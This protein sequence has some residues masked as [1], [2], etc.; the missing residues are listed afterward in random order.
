MAD[1]GEKHPEIA[2]EKGIDADSA[3]GS[4]QPHQSDQ[5]LARH[6]KVRPLLPHGP[7]SP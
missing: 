7:P 2:V 4:F 3:D 1:Y 5:K 6:L